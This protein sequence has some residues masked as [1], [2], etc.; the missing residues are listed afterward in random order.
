MHNTSS[1]LHRTALVAVPIGNGSNATSNV[2]PVTPLLY[3]QQFSSNQLNNQQ[4]SNSSSSQQQQQY[5]TATEVTR[6][7]STITS[8]L[9]TIV[10]QSSRI[11]SLENLAV[12]L[13]TTMKEMQD[14]VLANL[15]NP[16]ITRKC[17]HQ[18]S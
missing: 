9:E 1:N 16:N 14:Y 17:L 18:S 2:Y 12:N 13:A 8:M 15:L 6:M 7:N 5:A 11:Q 4:Q 10:Q 3:G